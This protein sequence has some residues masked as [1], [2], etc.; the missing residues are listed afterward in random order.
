MQGL[1]F[2]VIFVLTSFSCES[3]KQNKFLLSKSCCRG[4][5]S[6]IK[7][8]NYKFIFIKYNPIKYH[9]KWGAFFAA[10]EF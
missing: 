9:F 2:Q 7:I 8:E 5:Y 3:K 10:V 1:D 6:N 4:V